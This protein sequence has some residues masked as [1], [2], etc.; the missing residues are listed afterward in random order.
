MQSN[1]AGGGDLSWA[2]GQNTDSWLLY[3]AWTSSHHGVWDQGENVPRKTEM[4]GVYASAVTQQSHP[5]GPGP[6]ISPTRGTRMLKL[7]RLLWVDLK[8]A[9]S[10][11]IFKVQG[12][13]TTPWVTRSRR[14]SGRVKCEGDRSMKKFSEDV[15]Q[16]QG[17]RQW[18][19]AAHSF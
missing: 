13:K 11:D 17:E 19:R 10:I 15:P 16:N 3:V 9:S 6:K 7:F 2:V 1:T 12:S 8:A 14:R 4:E 18:L 5:P